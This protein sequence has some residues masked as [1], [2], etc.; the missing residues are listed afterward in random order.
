MKRGRLV[1]SGRI[2]R[3]R[4]TGGGR[5]AGRRR[6]GRRRDDGHTGG[7]RRDSGRIGLPA[8]VFSVWQLVVL[9]PFHAPVLEPNFNLAF[10]QAEA[11]GDL[12]PTAPRQV[13]VEVEFFFQLEN[14]V[15]GVGRS[16]S[17]WFHS[18]RESS[19]G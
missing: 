6:I 12:D 10:G 7:C 17:F 9:F 15:A 1:G 8:D 2:G 19:V 18:R 4:V 16:L 5:R 11:V 13:A 3:L 14:L